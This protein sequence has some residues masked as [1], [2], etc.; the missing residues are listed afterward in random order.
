MAALV[1]HS[2]ASGAARVAA[3]IPAGLLALFASLLV[4][5]GLACGRERRKYVLA[6]SEQMMTAATAMLG[7]GHERSSIAS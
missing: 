3:V 5:L 7:A 2:A 6:A 1:L 4:L